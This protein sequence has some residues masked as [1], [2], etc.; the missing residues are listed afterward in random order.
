MTT[1]LVMPA[2]A[3]R[4]PSVRGWLSGLWLFWGVIAGIFAWHETSTTP[5]IVWAA[6]SILLFA[7]VGAVAISGSPGYSRRVL[8]DVSRR[9]WRRAVQ[10][11]F[12]SGAE[13]GMLWALGM[14][15]LTLLVIFGIEML[16]EAGWK[17]PSDDG[18]NAIQLAGF[19]FT[20]TAYIW[21]V[22]AVWRYGL[23]RWINYRLAGVVAGA[24]ALLGWALPYLAA[25]GA[26]AHKVT[27]YF[28]NA[29]AFFD[30]DLPDV[31]A[32]ATAATIWA[33]LACAVILPGLL[34]A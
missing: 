1:S 4:A 24:L 13:N 11:P 25:L 27:W 29:F 14:G 34:A 9:R 26:P 7:L 33:G 30:D 28:G 15:G 10:F 20:L 16:Q 18:P 22:R 32:A 6:P 5:M 17:A 31:V 21:T 12:F 23:G 2:A 3:N 19:F 8:G